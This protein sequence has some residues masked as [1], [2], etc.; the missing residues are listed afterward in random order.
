MSIPEEVL[1]EEE[2]SPVKPNYEEYSIND[3]AMEV[4]REEQI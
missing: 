2:E 3:V 1:E 4:P